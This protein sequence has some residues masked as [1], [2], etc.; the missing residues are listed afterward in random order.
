M[1]KNVTVQK[2][3]NVRVYYRRREGCP[4]GVPLLDRWGVIYTEIDLD[5]DQQAVK[6]VLEAT[7]GQWITPIFEIRGRVYVQ[8]SE[9]ELARA[10]GLY[11]RPDEV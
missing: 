11:G 6:L 9:A 4:K 2:W 3:P 5:V 7:G 10:L 1:E 8:P